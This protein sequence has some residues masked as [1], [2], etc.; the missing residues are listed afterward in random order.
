[1]DRQ[2]PFLKFKRVA[3]TLSVIVITIL[4][5]GTIKNSGFNMGIDFVGGTKITASFEQ[6]VDEASIRNTL[7]DYSPTVQSI[8]SGERNEYMIS[9]RIISADE[10]ELGIIAEIREKLEAEYEKVEFLSVEN[11]GP[12]IGDYLRQSAVKLIIIS[13][14][15]MSL[16]LAFRFEVK[17]A[18]AAVVTLIHDLVIVISFCGFAGVEINIPAVAAML[19]IFGYSVND[20]IV[21]FD[22]IR[23]NVNLE[24]KTTLPEIVNRSI[25]QSIVRSLVTSLT[26]LLAVL[27]LYILGG[28][29]INEFALVLLVGIIVG[30]YSSIYI[31]APILLWWQS[32]RKSKS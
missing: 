20:S 24:T 3:L 25:N 5:A 30:T 29:G 23:E 31:S 28:E 17:Y 11:V 21:I 32:L 26:T 9:T 15:L 2:I 16:Y 6:G 8:G 19:T 4:V 14:I 22:R 13:V 7:T 10:A 18:V 27:A 1:M 12:A